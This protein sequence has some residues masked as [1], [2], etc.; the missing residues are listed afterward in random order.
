MPRKTALAALALS[1]ALI[2]G[3]SFTA[4]PATEAAFVALV[5]AFPVALMGLGLAGPGQRKRRGLVLLL[6]AGVL[7]EAA[8]VGILVLS[9][10]EDPA[11]WFGGLPEATAVLVYGLGLAPLPIMVAAY[12]LTFERFPNGR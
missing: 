5:M 4:H 2:L 12:V 11:G 6:A 10:R 3:L 8:G 9:G 1:S 7:L